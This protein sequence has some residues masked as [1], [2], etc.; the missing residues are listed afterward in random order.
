MNKIKLKKI[1]FDD[2]GKKFVS[3][4]IKYYGVTIVTFFIVAATIAGTIIYQN[5]YSYEWSEEEKSAYVSLERERVDFNEKN[6][7][8]IV[9]E[10]KRKKDV[11][12]KEMSGA[13]EIFKKSD[14]EIN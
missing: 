12:N 11:Y 6:F 13:K 5:V 2:L 14:E 1:H 10:S 8:I 9:E 7:S 3:L 4:W